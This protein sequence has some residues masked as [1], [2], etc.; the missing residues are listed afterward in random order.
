MVLAHIGRTFKP[1][2]HVGRIDAQTT[3]IAIYP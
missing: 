3:I 1:D 2:G